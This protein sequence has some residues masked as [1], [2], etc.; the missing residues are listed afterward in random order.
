[1]NLGSA[2]ERKSID[3][4]HLQEEKPEVGRHHKRREKG[5]F[6]FFGHTADGL[7]QGTG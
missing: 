2:S 1:M 4:K 5:M 6:E 7:K 3:L